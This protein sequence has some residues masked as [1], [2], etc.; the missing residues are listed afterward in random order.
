MD[1]TNAIIDRNSVSV[2]YIDDTE[3]VATAK[4]REAL[5]SWFSALERDEA[6]FN[7]KLIAKRG[8]LQSNSCLLCVKSK[9]WQA[10][11]KIIYNSP[12]SCSQ[13]FL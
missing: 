2:T 4:T 6:G 5:L 11:S 13:Y 8:D 7:S 1:A 9:H 12:S 3:A 10:G